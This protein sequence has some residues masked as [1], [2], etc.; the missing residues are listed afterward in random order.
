MVSNFIYEYESWYGNI[1]EL[2]DFSK[3]WYT[4]YV[5]S[6]ENDP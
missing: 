6:K 3:Y 2:A 5:F 1:Y 4:A